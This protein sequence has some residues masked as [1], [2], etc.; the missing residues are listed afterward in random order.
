MRFSALLALHAQLRDGAIMT[1]R[2]VRH[3]PRQFKSGDMSGCLLKAYF[4]VL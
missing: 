3:W 4:S 2:C 1:M